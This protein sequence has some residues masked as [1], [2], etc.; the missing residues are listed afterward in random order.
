MAAKDLRKILNIYD[1]VT[2]MDPID[3]RGTNVGFYRNRIERVLV[4][5]QHADMRIRIYPWRPSPERRAPRRAAV[6]RIVGP[7]DPRQ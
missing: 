6:E 1:E 4:D 3:L 7:A 5:G 2:K